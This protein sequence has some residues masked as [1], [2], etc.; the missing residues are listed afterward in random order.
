MH[1]ES[2]RPMFKCKNKKC[3]AVFG[4]IEGATLKIK[5]ANGSSAVIYKSFAVIVKCDDCGAFSKWFTAKKQ[6][7]L[8]AQ[9]N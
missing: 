5:L 6:I 2:P 8:I 1:S 4:A 9:I 7:D 3:D